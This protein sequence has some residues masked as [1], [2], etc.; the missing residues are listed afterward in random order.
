M[1]CLKI[2][3]L[4]S[5]HC[6]HSQLCTIIHHG[7]AIVTGSPMY[8]NSD[9]QHV[10]QN[11]Q[12]EHIFITP[13][14]HCHPYC[15]SL[16]QDHC[17]GLHEEVAA[18]FTT[19]EV[20]CPEDCMSWTIVGQ[21]ATQGCYIEGGGFDLYVEE[22]IG[23]YVESQAAILPGVDGEFLSVIWGKIRVNYSME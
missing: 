13:I 11:A 12:P 8:F 2:V 1:V 16:S 22:E 23:V 20:I 5:L 7:M 21:W 18:V 9:W 19:Q 15:Q 17:W 4:A 6:L 14:P 3:S 10:V